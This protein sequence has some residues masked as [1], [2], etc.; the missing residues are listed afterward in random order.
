MRPA[1]ARTEKR[2]G[3]F[4]VDETVGVCHEIIRQ[5]AFCPRLSLRNRNGIVDRRIKYEWL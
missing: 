3:R 4:L 1:Y 2:R 5:T